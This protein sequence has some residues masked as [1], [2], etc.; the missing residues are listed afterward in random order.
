MPLTMSFYQF[1]NYSPFNNTVT[2]TVPPYGVYYQTI[3]GTSDTTFRTLNPTTP[4]LYHKAFDTIILY[5]IL[6]LAI[7]SSI[8]I[9]DFNTI[10]VSYFHINTY[11]SRMTQNELEY[12]PLINFWCYDSHLSL[13]HYQSRRILP[14]EFLPLTLLIS[15]MLLRFV[16]LFTL[17]VL[18]ITLSVIIFLWKFHC[19]YHESFFILL[20]PQFT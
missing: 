14:S 3:V 9:N 8:S 19:I 12:Y 7:I 20:S 16:P 2:S 17:V 15:I 10:V 1:Q 6:N 18:I 13:F 4:E 11:L 5:R